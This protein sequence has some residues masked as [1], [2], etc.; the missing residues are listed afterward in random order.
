MRVAVFAEK[1]SMVQLNKIF[2]DLKIP[3]QSISLVDKMAQ[4]DLSKIDLLIMSMDVCNV[5]GALNGTNTRNVPNFVA[6]GGICWILHQEREGWDASWLPNHLREN[7]RIDIKHLPKMISFRK[8]SPQRSAYIGPWII[9]RDHQVFHKPNFLDETDFAE[10]DVDPDGL[11]LK[12]TAVNAITRHHGWSKVA[13]YEDV[14][15]PLEDGALIMQARHG[16]G[17]Y[18]WTQTLSP[19][20]VWHME[21]SREKE[22]WSKFLANIFQYFEDFKAGREIEATAEIHPWS[23]N[24]DN[25]ATVSMKLPENFAVS[26]IEV[27]V[28]LDDGTLLSK[29]N[30]VFEQ[31]DNYA[32]FDYIPN[33]AGTHRINAVAF[34]D[35]GKSAYVD[36]FLKVTDNITRY[37]FTTHHH[38]C[39]DWA[40]ENLGQ[41]YGSAQRWKQDAIFLASGLFYQRE[42][43]GIS[44]LYDLRND[45]RETVN[46]IGNGKYQNELSKLKNRLQEFYL[47]TTGHLRKKNA[48][49]KSVDCDNN[50]YSKNNTAKINFQPTKGI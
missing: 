42:G 48:E 10:W 23:V 11:S 38:Y 37:R 28:G 32:I 5:F 31:R 25:K 20:L 50:N 45:R 7:L 43:S 14:K 22:T 19:G 3:L 26:R 1:F 27:K 39:N 36:L 6:N 2:D 15:T 47:R 13:G 24:A 29:I 46:E 33:N 16:K 40:T 12:T 34:S 35:D 41:V 9:E 17:L 8:N 21:G 4:I 49:M 44:E 18:F 30:C